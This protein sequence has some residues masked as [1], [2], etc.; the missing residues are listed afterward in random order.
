MIYIYVCV[1]VEQSRETGASR[2]RV[3]T[4]LNKCSPE[5]SWSGYS[6]VVRIA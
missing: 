5:W 6:F 1:W 2:K 3:V 4:D